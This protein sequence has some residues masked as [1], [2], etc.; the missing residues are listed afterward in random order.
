MKRIKQILLD[1]VLA[2][3]IGFMAVGGAYYAWATQRPDIVAGINV[4]VLIGPMAMAL[5]VSLRDRRLKDKAYR[6]ASDDGGI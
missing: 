2:V 4:G 5:A 6:R 3:L 1:A